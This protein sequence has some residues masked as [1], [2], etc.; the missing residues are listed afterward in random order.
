MTL[1]VR[2]I[3]LLLLFLLPPL[4]LWA[5]PQAVSIGVL[6]KSGEDTAVKRWSA[7]ADYLSAIIPAYHFTIVPLGFTE[8]HEAVEQGR[9]D[10][11][12]ANPAFYVELEKLYG[13]SRIATL[14]NQNLP[15]QQT[16]TFGG[17]IFTKADR[18]DINTLTD[19]KGKSFMAV[20]SLSFGGW[21]AAWREFYK[22]G[23]DPFADLHA[24]SMSIRPVIP[25]ES[26][27]RFHGKAVSD[28]TGIRPDMRRV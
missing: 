16:T 4:S 13:V 15:T 14:I 28:S 26:G 17:T 10:F 27:H 6:A 18:Q 11:V 1:I 7:T 2:T 20:D 25:F 22:Q 21:I 9:I 23:I 8:I 5:S 24:N 12:L 19:L 3:C